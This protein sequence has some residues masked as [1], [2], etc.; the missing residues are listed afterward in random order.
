MMVVSCDE[1]AKNFLQL[2]SLGRN[3]PAS[4]KQDWFYQRSEKNE[5]W[6][7]TTEQDYLSELLKLKVSEN[8]TN[9]TNL[10]AK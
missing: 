7:R 2:F 5:Y 6:K 1:K 9:L 10:T 8:W 3:N 4:R